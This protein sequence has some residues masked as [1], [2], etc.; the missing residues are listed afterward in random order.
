MGTQRKR[1]KSLMRTRDS[2]IRSR[3]GDVSVLGPRDGQHPC[4]I[5]MYADF[6]I[7]IKSEAF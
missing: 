1:K 2:L 7:K 6:L 5:S 4:S 3:I